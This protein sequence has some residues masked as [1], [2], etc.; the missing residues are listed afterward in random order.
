MKL[1]LLFTTTTLLASLGMVLSMP[2]FQR[3]G[4]PGAN[5]GSASIV[6]LKTSSGQVAR[7]ILPDGPTRTKADLVSSKLV[8]SGQMACKDAYH[9]RGGGKTLWCE[10]GQLVDDQQAKATL[11]DACDVHRG[12]KL[13]L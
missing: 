9:H 8:A 7:C 1:S 2:L 3:L 11:E 5:E 10:Q 6:L 4:F 12:L 13:G